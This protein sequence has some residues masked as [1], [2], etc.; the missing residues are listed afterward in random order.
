MYNLSNKDLKIEVVT[1]DLGIWNV[2]GFLVNRVHFWEN[3]S[4]CPD[5]LGILEAV[6]CFGENCFWNCMYQYQV[7]EAHEWDHVV[8]DHE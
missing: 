4:G 8:V 7:I 3:Y 5:I 6:H 2:W 1:I